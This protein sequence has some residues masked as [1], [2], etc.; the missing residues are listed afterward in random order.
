MRAIWVLVL[1]VG[2]GSSSGGP[3]EDVFTD[4][5]GSLEIEGCGYSITTRLGAE[6]PRVAT[7]TLGPDPTP[8]LVHL[9]F[10]GDPRTSMVI[11]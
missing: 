7:D 11:Q 8:P 2:C 4:V 1:A 10:V 6:P 5:G 9:G 3:D